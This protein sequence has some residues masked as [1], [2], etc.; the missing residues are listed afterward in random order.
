MYKFERIDEDKFKIVGKDKEYTFTRV[1]ELA[2]ELQSIDLKKTIKLIEF[3]AER[4]ETLE[5]TKLRVTRQEGNKTIVDES[6]LEAIKKAFEPEITMEIINNI[7]QKQT[8]LKMQD[9]ISELGIEINEAEQFG[10]DYI[11]ALSSGVT[12]ETPRKQD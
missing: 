6:N 3:L 2:K 4:G 7:T 12:E 10:R 8:G 11:K 1:V 5:T 9:I